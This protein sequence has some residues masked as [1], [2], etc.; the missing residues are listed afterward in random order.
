MKEAPHWFGRPIVS[1]D[2]VHDLDTRAAIYEFNAKEP[3][4]QAEQHA[5]DDYVKERRLDAAAFHLSGMKAAQ[6][7]GQM[8]EARKHGMLYELHLQ[9]LGMNPMG[10][11][12][13][14]VNAK[15]RAEDS[16]KVYKFKSHRG[17][18]YALQ[19][20]TKPEE[21]KSEDEKLDKAEGRCQWRLGERRCKNFGTRRVEGRLFCHHHEPHASGKNLDE[22]LSTLHKAASIAL[23]LGKK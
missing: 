12:P 18:F 19:D 3:R 15:L 16:A 14:E 7:A 9:A 10:P 17:D 13:P 6:G 20:A 4:H 21:P 23:E 11:V 8:D 1:A 2:D 22:R 5:Y